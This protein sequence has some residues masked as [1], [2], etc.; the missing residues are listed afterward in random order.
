MTFKGEIR[1]SL[2]RSLLEKVRK[3]N[4]NKYLYSIKLRA[5]LKTTY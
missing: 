4:Y 5:G 2:I 1:D 3:R